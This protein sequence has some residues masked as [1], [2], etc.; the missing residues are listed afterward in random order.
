MIQHRTDSAKPES[1]VVKPLDRGEI[2]QRI[3]HGKLA[4]F[5]L[6]NAAYGDLAVNW[7]LLLSEVLRP[8]GAELHYFVGALDANISALLLARGLPTLRAG[9]SGAHDGVSDAPPTNFRLQFS[10]FRALGVT[11]ADLIAWL[12]SA[13]R[14]VV[15]S[16]VDC[17]WLSPPHFLLNMLPEADLMAGTDCLHV[18]SDD[19]RSTRGAVAPRCGHHPGSGWAAWFNTGVL[20]WRAKSDHALSFAIR[21]RDAMAAVSCAARGA[22]AVA[23]R[24]SITSILMTT[25]D[26]AP[27]CSVTGARRR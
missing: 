22:L 7:A 8:I 3:P 23:S 1:L 16:D 19:D 14:D 6:A 17:A 18:D 24:K 10:K 5:T 12:L 2:L 15:V 11:K 20:L 9:L 26:I 4:F 13:G 27:Q 21:W 25:L